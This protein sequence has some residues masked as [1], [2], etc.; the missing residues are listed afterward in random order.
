MDTDGRVTL[1]V[2]GK[3]ISAKA[4]TTILRAALDAGIY[5]PNLCEHAD[6]LPV[7]ACRMCVVRVAGR[8]GVSAACSTQAEDGMEVATKSDELYRLRRLTLELLL[9]AHPDECSSCPKYL[10]CEMQNLNQYLGAN[11]ARLRRRLNAW[12]ED[13]SNPL[14]THDFSRCILCERC[15]RACEDVRGVGILKV[16]KVNGK[17]RIGIPDGPSLAEAGCRFCGACAEVCPTG[18]LRDK[19]GLIDRA[20]DRRTE[21]VPCAAECPAGIDIPRYVRL[22]REG[23]PAEAAAVVRE[24]APFPETLGY[25]CDHLC[26][27]ACR[28]GHVSGPISIRALKRYAA[29]RDDG[30]WRSRSKRLPPTGKKV[31]V[32]GSGPAGLTAAYYLAKQGHG[33]VVREALPKAGGM[34]RYGIPRY[35]LP[36]AVL[37]RELAALGS[38]GFALETGTEARSA[39]AALAESFD[40]VLVATGAHGGVRLPIDG[41][42]LPGALVNIGFLRAAAM[43]SPPPIG[44]RVAVLG[45]GN[46]A[47]D[48]A[49]TARRLGA[50]SVTVLCLEP[51]DAMTASP[52]EIAEALADGCEILGSRSF[53]RIIG[54]GGRVAGVECAEVARF[55]FDA[56]GRAQI[57]LRPGSAHVV[58]ADTVIFAVGQRPE[59]GPGFGLG[60]TRGGRVEA[61][62]DSLSTA[63]PGVFAAGDVV[64]GTK[65]VVAAIQAGRTAASSIDRFLGGDG[66]ISESLAPERAAEARIGKRDGF[67]ALTRVEARK[68]GAAERLSGFRLVDEGL[69]A[70]AGRLEAARC[71]RCDLRLALAPSRFWNEYES[72]AGSAAVAEGPDAEPKG[73]PR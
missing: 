62:P 11:P 41:A 8:G 15:V 54:E 4:G 40:A 52:E 69:D 26:E 17:P 7:G 57:E 32:I 53:L 43:G 63:L 51:R 33:V 47:F 72:E 55:G 73:A 31:A 1:S 61:D 16:V 20:G 68:L 19:E 34:L 67:A 14:F 65:S 44:K 45:G 50:E 70:E 71:L 58:K 22:V 46:V 24:R 10:R 25:V 42:D 59:L 39:S 64:S 12:P 60:L 35:R 21:Y 13:E 36:E 38:A 28:R 2:D 66:D 6:L 56:E 27:K 5:I 18:A 3:E 37:D 23:F 30:A 49:G 9:S 48:C 29:E